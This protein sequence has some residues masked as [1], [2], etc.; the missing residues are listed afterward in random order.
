M[1]DL[2]LGY[3]WLNEFWPGRLEPEIEVFSDL[4]I[5]QIKFIDHVDKCLICFI[6]TQMIDSL[7]ATRL[8]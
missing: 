2:L 5:I 3:T 7:K 4:F 6:H 8:I 1:G